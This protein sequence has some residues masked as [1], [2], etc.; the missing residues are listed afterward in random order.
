MKKEIVFQAK[1]DTSDFDKSV[2]QMQKKLKE[3][4]APADMVRAQT[5]TQQ[6]LQ[7]QG[8]GNIS[9]PSMDAYNRA[10][11]QARRE[12]DNAIREQVTGQEKL[13]KLIAQRAEKVKQLTDEQSKMVKG[14][15]EELAIKEKIARVEENI[16][17]QRQMYLQRD[18]AINQ[19]LNVRDKSL[20]MPQHSDYG[21][22]PGNFSGAMDDFIKR[23][24]RK[25]WEKVGRRGAIISGAGYALSAGADIYRDFAAGPIRSE[26]AM[27]NAI[28]GTAGRD[29]NNIYGH[30]TAFEMN[31]GQERARAMQQA[32]DNMSANKI[33]DIIKLT[34]NTAMVVGGG[35]MAAK[36]AGIG[37]AAGTAVPLVGNAVGAAAGAIPGTLVAGKGLLNMLGDER[38]RS[39]MLSPFSSTASNRYNSM[40]A[41]QLANDYNTSLEGQKNQNPFKKAAVGEYEQNFMRNLGMQR[42]MGLQ[43]DGFYGK[44]GFMQQ[45]IDAGFLPE[46]AMEMAQSIQGAGGSTRMMRDSSFALQLQRGSNL[47]NAGQIMGSLSGGLGSS[48]ASRQAAIKIGAEATKQGL[49]DSKFAEEQRRFAQTTAEFISRSGAST[50][51]DFERILSTFGNFYSEKTTRGLDAAKNAYEEYQQISSSVTGPRGVMRAAGFLADEKLSQLDTVSKQALLQIPEEQL[52]EDNPLVAGLARKVGETPSDFINR[53]KKVNQG[54]V[55]RFKQAD[56]IRDR[57]REK[58]IDMTRI[59]DPEYMATQDPSVQNDVTSLLAFQ[60]MEHGY[61]DSRT[62]MARAAGTVGRQEFSDVQRDAEASFKKRLE[63]GTGRMEDNTIRA[64]AGDASTVLK[65]FNEM[66]SGMDEAAKSAAAFTHQIRE[67]NAALLKALEEAKNGN[68]GSQLDVITNFLKQNASQLQ[69]QAQKSEQ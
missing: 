58:G 14:S 28:Q 34:G 27:G 40:L 22:M 5:L 24:A 65:N 38:Q 23:N 6:R 51:S 12:M 8:L 31:F 46:Q 36:G 26:S 4:Y 60:T 45:A 15:Q 37:A 52:T 3:I 20:N 61:K 48:E 43:N 39:L 2:E 19:A 62:M 56:D 66:R 16:H 32:L 47:T 42:M 9:Q 57:L 68:N 50:G 59:N 30:R 33:A 25:R 10:T 41:E 11:Q 35:M 63:G 18:A 69:T 17:R 67:M 13:G 55:S 44:S 1:F 64:Q 29:V 49:D 53:I 54:A 21:D 7:G